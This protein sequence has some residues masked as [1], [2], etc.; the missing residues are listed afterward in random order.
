MRFTNSSALTT[1]PTF[2]RASFPILQ[3]CKNCLINKRP[4]PMRQTTAIKVPI[5]EV[6]QCWDASMLGEGTDAI[7]HTINEPGNWHEVFHVQT[8]KLYIVATAMMKSWLQ[9]DAPTAVRCDNGPAFVGELIQVLRNVFGVKIRL[10]Q[11]RQAYQ[12]GKIERSSTDPEAPRPISAADVATISTTI[13]QEALLH[14]HQYQNTYDGKGIV[15]DSHIRVGDLVTVRIPD[16]TRATKTKSKVYMNFGRNYLSSSF[17]KDL[18]FLT[19]ISAIILLIGEKP[20]EELEQIQEDGDH[21]RQEISEAFKLGKCVI[22]VYQTEFEVT[23]IRELPDD[24]CELADREYVELR[25]DS[26]DSSVERVVEI[27]EQDCKR[28]QHL[29]NGYQ[30]LRSQ[31][32][33]ANEDCSTVV[34]VPLSPEVIKF[35]DTVGMSDFVQQIAEL[36]VEC[37]SDL[38]LIDNET[39]DGMGCSFIQRRKFSNLSASLPSAPLP[40]PEGVPPAQLVEPLKSTVDAKQK[41]PPPAGYEFGTLREA[42][43][44]GDEEK[45]KS[46]LEKNVDPNCWEERDIIVGLTTLPLPKSEDSRCTLQYHV[47]TTLWRRRSL[48]LG[49]P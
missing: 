5:T 33:S 12:N 36:G 25:S 31:G 40:E 20:D 14:H 7:L 44:W 1:S 23:T 45:V 24:I 11:S 2:P 42:A 34:S 48:G 49:R 27:I 10:I 47:V 18:D 39:L 29:P 28:A 41:G 9:Y 8:E 21:V 3:G 43:Y 46:L 30:P 32:D 17:Q 6:V 37:V 35:L 22:P 38:K 4:P 16:A 26:Y 19:K 15:R 13:R